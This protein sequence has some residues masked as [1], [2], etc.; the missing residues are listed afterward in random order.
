MVERDRWY[1]LAR[2]DRAGKDDLLGLLV[3][4]A[5]GRAR[6]LPGLHA[7]QQR[8]QQRPRAGRAAAAG[9]RAAD[10]EAPMIRRARSPTPHGDGRLVTH[11]RAASPIAT[12]LLS[13]GAGGGI[14]TRDL[15]ALAAAPAR[16]RASRVVLFEQPWRVAGRKVATAAADARRRPAPPPPTT[17]RTRT[18][19]GR[20]RPLRRGPLGG[21]LRATALGR[22]RLPGAVLPA[23]PARP[24]REV[25]ARRAARRRGADAGRPGRARHDRPA[26]GVPGDR[27]RP[28]RRPGGRPRRSR[29]RQ[30]RPASARTRR[31]RSSSSR[32]WSGSCA[33]SPGIELSQR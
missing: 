18:P 5:P 12:L 28:G 32:R 25:A 15:E 33:R 22:R 27:R 9:G 24:A 2:P 17:L 20:R 31:W 16:A 4:A 8:A 29:C 1:E 11:R 10:D 21:P 19:A 30:A 13:H 6:G 26:R 14:D 23:A 7:G 3:P